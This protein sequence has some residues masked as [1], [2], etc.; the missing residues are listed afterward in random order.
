MTKHHARVLCSV[1]LAFASGAALAQA[2]H[3][4]RP[5]AQAGAEVFREHCAECHSFDLRG[6]YGP[7]LTG[8][9]FASSLQSTNMSAAALYGFISSGMPLNKPGS[10]SQTEY[11][12][13]FAFILSRNGF[14]PGK[15]ALN[16]GSLGTIDLLPLPGKTAS[17]LW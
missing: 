12:D 1:V 10:L 2:G 7:A 9:R 16:A 5:Q 13:V 11:L 15:S 8:R 17:G 4:S 3:F 14:R 6:G